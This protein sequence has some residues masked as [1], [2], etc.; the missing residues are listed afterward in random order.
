MLSYNQ[1]LEHL[2]RHEQQPLLWELDKV[3]AHQGP[4]HQKDPNYQ[5]S[6]YNVTV[7]W[8]NGEITDEPLS[9]IALDAPVACAIYTKEKGLLNLPGWKRFKNIA[10]QQGKSFIDM[11]KVELRNCHRKSKYKNGIEI[12]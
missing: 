7:K 11:N 9:V 5:N 10:K 6:K 4:L 3:I 8:A 2:E 1:L 12:P